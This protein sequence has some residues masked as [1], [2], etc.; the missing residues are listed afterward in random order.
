[1][2]YRMFFL[3]RNFVSALLCVLK[4]EKTE[5]IK[6]CSKK[7]RY[8]NQPCVSHKIPPTM[9]QNLPFSNQKSNFCRGALPHPQTHSPAGRKM[10]HSHLH[11][12]CSL[13]LQIITNTG[14]LSWTTLSTDQGRLLFSCASCRPIG[15]FSV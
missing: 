13:P 4:P 3:G 8:F 1:M 15:Y 6:T 2:V 14:L 11:P 12:R 5:N 7:P 9:Q 10:T